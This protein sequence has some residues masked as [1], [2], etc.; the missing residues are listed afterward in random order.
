MTNILQYD[1]VNKKVL[2]P[3]P[4]ISQ[5]IPVIAGTEAGHFFAV[6]IDTPDFVLG[7]RQLDQDCGSLPLS[8]GVQTRIR[9]EL[10]GDQDSNIVAFIEALG[11][12]QKDQGH[13]SVVRDDAATIVEAVS[14]YVEASF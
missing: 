8:N 12:T 4:V 11:F 13:F 5:I 10:K 14:A 2:A 1:L 7:V 3:M 9:V 6:A